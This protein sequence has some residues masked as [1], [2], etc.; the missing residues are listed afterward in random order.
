MKKTVSMIYRLI[1][2]IV[3]VWALWSR[4]G[5]IPDTAAFSE[6]SVFSDTVNAGLALAAFLWSIKSAPPEVLLKMKAIFASLAVAVLFMNRALF[7]APVDLWWIINVLLPFMAVLDWI[8]FDKK[9]LLKIW[10]L[11]LWLLA[12]F[13]LMAILGFDVDRMLSALLPALAFLGLMLLSGNLFSGKKP[14]KDLLSLLL[15][16]GFL[17]LECYAFYL[18]S[19]LNV[20]SF[21]GNLKY[22]T[23]IANLFAFSVVAVSVI[24]NFLGFKKA[25]TYL[26][27]IKGCAVVLLVIAG[28]LY[29]G[30]FKGNPYVGL[31]TLIHS[32]I[33]PAFLL[34]DY[35]VFDSKENTRGFD[36]LWWCLPVFGYS[37]FYM[38]RPYPYILYDD[39]NMMTFV[40]YGIL[41]LVVGYILFAVDKLVKR[42]N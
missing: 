11:I 28:D 12:A 10:D 14:K 15:E 22:Y 6:L 8:L 3:S 35:L 39:M 18:L 4:F 9:G 29:Y 20:E 37:V 5:K 40:W 26:S 41:A 38:M 2:V 30:Y 23:P 17:A 1:F 25:G 16:V 7:F 13:G 42:F 24:V 27:R 31:E 32:I 33:C 19:G 36:P 34:I 21:V